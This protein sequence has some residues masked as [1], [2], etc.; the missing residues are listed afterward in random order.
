MHGRVVHQI[1]EDE[2]LE[3]LWQLGD[4]QWSL[5]DHLVTVRDDVDT[6]ANVVTHLR[7]S[8]IRAMQT[9]VGPR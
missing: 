4:A 2:Q 9:A 3:T 1:V 6:A 7:Y 5:G 8:A